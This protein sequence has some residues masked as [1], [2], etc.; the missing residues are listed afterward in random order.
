MNK[1]TK[2]GNHLNLEH[3]IKVILLELKNIPKKPGIYKMINSSDEPI[4]IGKA[5]N[6]YKRVLSYTKANKL[7]RRSCS[8]V[9]NKAHYYIS[10]YR[11]LT[12]LDPERSI[13]KIL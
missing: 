8:M 4:Y 3:G 2:V 10:I 1:I 5:K 9:L 7:N 12:F 11:P 13:R 6:L